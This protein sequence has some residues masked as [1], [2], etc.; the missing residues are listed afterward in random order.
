MS[1]VVAAYVTQPAVIW[2]SR[3]PK[4]QRTD[5]AVLQCGANKLELAASNRSVTQPLHSDNSNAD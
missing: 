2:L 4:R 1:Q 5:H 3:G